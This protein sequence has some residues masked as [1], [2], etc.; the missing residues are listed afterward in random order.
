[1]RILGHEFGLF[2]SGDFAL[3]LAIADL[4][5]LGL[6]LAFGPGVDLG[7]ILRDAVGGA[8]VALRILHG[9]P[10]GLDCLL[11]RLQE[12]LLD[13]KIMISNSEDGY[14]IFKV[15]LSLHMRLFRINL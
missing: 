4:V 5:H 3:F 2:E 8:E 9:H 7:H 13:S 6:N 12:F 15:F 10:V 1:M 14:A 11:V